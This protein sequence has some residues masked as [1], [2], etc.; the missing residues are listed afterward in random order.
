MRFRVRV[1][2]IVFCAIAFML[3]SVSTVLAKSKTKGRIGKINLQAAILLHPTM[4][5]YDPKKVAFKA[6][7]NLISKSLIKAQAKERKSKIA[8]LKNIAKKLSVDL[9]KAHRNHDA[10]LQ[11]ISML[12]MSKLE[13][14][15]TGPALYNKKRYSIEESR[16][17][18]THLTKL[19]SIAAKMRANDKKIEQLSRIRGGVGYI[20]PVNTEKKIK[21]I[22]AE[23]HKHTKR[24]A[25]RKG[26][27]VVLNSSNRMVK[28]S[29]NFK[30]FDLI[31]VSYSKVM[32][33][34]FPK[35]LYSDSAAVSGHYSNIQDIAKSWLSRGDDILEPFA[36]QLRNT[37]V[38]IGGVDLTEEVIQSIFK[39][40]KID[41]NVG[42]AIS[43]VVNSF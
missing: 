26:I 28:L 8:M 41:K 16:A 43:Q 18:A 5:S 25:S 30:S 37:E 33:N 31:D 9:A 32:N 35:E 22:I 7:A 14:L 42:K 11:K 19:K 24:I 23:I 15:A 34:S 38:F 6:N 10:I 13:K 4:M 29:K 12:Y 40:H 20:S 39:A 3:A 21:E 17:E 36:I 1:K 2:F 27:K